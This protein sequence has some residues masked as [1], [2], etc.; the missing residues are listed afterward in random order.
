MLSQLLYKPNSNGHAMTCEIR[1]GKFIPKLLS[2]LTTSKNPC[3]TPYNRGCE[4][5]T[6]WILSSNGLDSL[7]RIFNAALNLH[8]SVLSSIWKGSRTIFLKIKKGLKLLCRYISD[9]ILSA[10]T[11]EQLPLQPATFLN[12]FLI[13]L[14]VS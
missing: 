7:R 11:F 13:H 4:D 1:M 6:L 5:L 8:V 10:Q 14:L 2:I 9:V 12:Y 3:H